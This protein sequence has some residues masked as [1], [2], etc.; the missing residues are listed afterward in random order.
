MHK[1]RTWKV[2]LYCRIPLEPPY[3]KLRDIMKTLRKVNI[4]GPRSSG[5]NMNGSGIGSY[6]LPGSKIVLGSYH[7]ILT[8]VNT[9]L[10]CPLFLSSQKG[11]NV[12]IKKNEAKIC[13][14]VK[15]KKK[16]N[17]HGPFFT[18]I[19]WNKTEF[20]E[21]TRWV[22]ILLRCVLLRYTLYNGRANLTELTTMCSPE[23]KDTS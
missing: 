2:C 4:F 20:L 5:Q 22:G 3:K 9:R 8:M 12:K 23:L 6:F 7:R 13:Y 14:R 21:L 17:R 16:K 10:L 15:K 1:A 11:K 18:R 19:C